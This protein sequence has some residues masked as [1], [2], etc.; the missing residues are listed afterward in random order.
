MNTDLV[1]AERFIDLFGGYADAASIGRFGTGRGGWSQRPL[2]PGDVMNHLQGEGSGIGVPPLRP[3]NTVVFAAIDLD[4]PD[5]YAAREMQTFIPGTSFLER[6]RSGNAHV[7]VF[8]RE[9]LEAWV[10]MGIL[11]E[12]TI[13]AGKEHVEVFPKNH[14]FA[15][16]RVG[17]YINLPYHGDE[18]HI[19]DNTLGMPF[20]SERMMTLETFLALAGGDRRNDPNAW[21]KRARF[22]LIEPPDQ[23]ESTREHGTQPTLHMCAE[24]VIEHRDDRPVVEGHRN[25]VY[26]ALARQLTNW[27][28]CDHEEALEMMKLVNEASP[29]PL[30]LVEIKRILGNA[31]RGAYTSTGCD[32]PG[33]LPYAHPNCPIAH[34][35]ASR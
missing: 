12:A 19:F 15:R 16:V 21:R 9:P 22:L 1:T 23:R 26:F 20:P 14:D 11:K 30:P 25:A 35:G 5:F 33:F 27:S 13:A 6:S 8:F 31:E 24:W 18:R 32:D 28:E 3:D 7:W 34:G 17:N 29:D 4:E 10:A 2:T